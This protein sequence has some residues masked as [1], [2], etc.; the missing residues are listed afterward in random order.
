MCVGGGGG[1]FTVCR[2]VGGGGGCSL[3]VG[4]GGGGAVRCL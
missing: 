1:L 2:S 3:S 4:L